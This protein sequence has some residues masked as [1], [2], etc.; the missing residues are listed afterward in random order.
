MTFTSSQVNNS[1]Q[2]SHNNFDFFRLVAALLVVFSHAYGQLF[3]KP[4]EIMYV[5]TQRRYLLST[6]GL[7]IFFTI[8]GYLICQSLHHSSSIKNF[9]WKRFLR[10]YPA[11]IVLTLL[12]V[13]VLG[14]AIT[15]VSLSAYFSSQQTYKFLIENILI[16]NSDLILPGVFNNTSVNPSAWTLPLEIKLYLVL[17]ILYVLK[18]LRNKWLITGVYLAFVLVKIFLPYHILDKYLPFQTAA[19]HDLGFFFMTGALLFIWKDATRFSWWG[20]MATAA[21]WFISKTLKVPGNV[22][23]EIFF[24]YSILWLCLKMPKIPF[25]KDDISYGVYIY[26]APVQKLVTQLTQRNVPLWLYNCTTVPIIILL[27]FLSW[28]L[29]EKRAL[30]KKNMVK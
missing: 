22:F 15:T 18:I 2:R 16:V 7:M 28:H 26:A 14:P 21:L 29:I 8:S 19:Y 1:L 30:K 10:I 6:F 20:I 25:W 13:F 4:I 3:D 11:Y 24:A 5:L 17:L 12:T 27:G 9:V 23:E